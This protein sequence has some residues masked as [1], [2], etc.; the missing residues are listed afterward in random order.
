MPLLRRLRVAALLCLA[1]P[2]LFAADRLEFMTQKDFTPFF[3]KYYWGT[4]LP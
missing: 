4:A 2:P 1:V 3:E